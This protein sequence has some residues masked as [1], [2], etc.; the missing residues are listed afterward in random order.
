[1]N[2]TI[3]S[4]IIRPANVLFSIEKTADAFWPYVFCM[5]HVEIERYRTQDAAQMRW[6]R[7]LREMQAAGAAE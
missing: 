6:D 7:E 2:Y 1:M 5:D 3:K 4:E